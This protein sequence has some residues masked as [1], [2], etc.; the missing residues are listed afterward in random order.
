[1]LRLNDWQNVSISLLLRKSQESCTILQ[2]YLHDSLRSKRTYAL[3]RSRSL[4]HQKRHKPHLVQTY[5][6]TRNTR[7]V[8]TD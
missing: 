8:G 4:R 3:N 2:A 1:M 7:Q 5:P 6:A